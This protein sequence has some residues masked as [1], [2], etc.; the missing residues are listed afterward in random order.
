VRR[1]SC[2]PRVRARRAP[3]PLAYASTPKTGKGARFS[4]KKAPGRADRV[5]KPLGVPI[6]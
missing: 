4:K 3:R 6:A 2:V 5:K 1:R